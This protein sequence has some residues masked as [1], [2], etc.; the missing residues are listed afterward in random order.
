MTPAKSSAADA[1]ADIADPNSASR[2]KQALEDFRTTSDKFSSELKTAAR[3]APPWSATYGL[4]DGQ[5]QGDVTTG[6][7]QEF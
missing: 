5:S 3:E 4:A 7:Y 1:P 2:G 6:M